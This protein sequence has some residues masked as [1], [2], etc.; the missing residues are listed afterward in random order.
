MLNGRFTTQPLTGVQRFGFEMA[1]ELDALLGD[2]LRIFTPRGGRAV[3]SSAEEIGKHDGHRWEQLELPRRARQAYLINLGN[4]APL[5]CSRQLVVIHDAGVFKVP[6]AYG[7]RFRAWYKAMQFWLSRNGTAIVSVSESSRADIARHLSI[8]EGRISVVPEGTDHLDRI[9]PDPGFLSEHGLQ[10]RRFVL[11]VGNLAA[12]KNLSAL[13]PLASALSQLGMPLVIAG[14]LKGG[15]YSNSGLAG[16]PQPACYV[17]RVS[18]EALKALYNAAACYVF[19]SRYEGYGLPA[20]EAMR[21]GCPVIAADIP[22]LR[23]TCGDA[24]LFVDPSVPET[25]ADSAARIIADG[26]LRLELVNR[27]LARTQRQTWRQAAQ[28]L[29]EIVEEKLASDPFAVREQ[30]ARA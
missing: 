2:R 19:P 26:A 13:A 10:P 24:A 8:P 14:N 11:A 23:E 28:C 9:M 1:K 27:G 29:L 3:L 21:C 16:L 30:I 20:A 4:T 18:D 6:E 25:F 7:L 22:A 15:A 5:F 17:G 12:H